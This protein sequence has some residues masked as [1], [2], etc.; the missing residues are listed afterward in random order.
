MRRPS[1]VSV[2]LLM[3]M[4][5]SSR[6]RAVDA[7]AGGAEWIPGSRIEAFADETVGSVDR[8]DPAAPRI[9]VHTPDPA[10]SYRAQF[11]LPL[12]TNSLPDE[13]LVLILMDARPENGRTA[14]VTVKL[15]QRD[16]PYTPLADPQ[17]V[18][19]DDSGPVPVLFRTTSRPP[20][21]ALAL[22]VFCGASEGAITMRNLRIICYPATYPVGSLPRVRHTYAGRDPDAPWRRAALSRIDAGRKADIT[23]TLRDEDGRPLSD[24]EVK[25]VLRRHAFGFGSAVTARRLLEAGPDGDR[26]REIVERY[27]SCVV[28]ENDLKD[29]EWAPQLSEPQREQRNVRIR[30]ALDWLEARRIR[31]RGHYLMQVARPPNLSDGLSADQIRQHLIGATRERI[32]TIGDR[33]VEWDVINHPI[34][35]PGA[36][37]LDRM[38]G[39]ERLDREVFDLARSLTKRPLW[40][41]EDQL[42]RPGAQSSNTLAY[43]RALRAEGYP[44]AGLG[45]QAHIH[46]SFLPDPEAILRLSEVFA[47]AAPRLAIT[48]FDVVVQADEELARDYSRDLLITCFSHPAYDSF[49]WWGFWAGA[50]WKPEAAS[51]SVDWTPRLRAEVFEQ[52]IGG[53]WRTIEKRRTDDEGVVLWHGFPGWY[54]VE[55]D[56]RVLPLQPA[57]VT[58][59]P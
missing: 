26:Y 41:N 42:F 35:W 34:A 29:F 3:V 22:V 2:A 25:L 11:R 40:V 37:M 15:Q 6:A 1:L 28:F 38:A 16:A 12:G 7:P 23:L 32:A 39:L 21:G 50:H 49:L 56:G 45:N 14:R 59:T 48:E 51:W 19:V 43:V 5:A 36:V 47:C 53:A 27:F 24:R 44:V 20:R 17:D 10:R 58:G 31:V 8:N 55:V 54:D 57:G 46:E 4:F 18:V 13:A 33:V 9:R 52:W 30:Q